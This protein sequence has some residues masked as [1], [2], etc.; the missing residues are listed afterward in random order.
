[1]DNTMALSENFGDVS[2]L[3]AC[4]QCG[5]CSSACPI[6]GVNDFNIRRIVRHIELDLVKEIADTP[7]PWY[8]TTCGRCESVCP[9]GIA[10]LDIIRPLRS[11]GPD[12]LAPDWPPCTK[13]CPAGI[14]IPAYLRLIAEGKPEEACA[15]IL[16]KVPF[17]GILGR[18]CMHPCEDACRR[19]EVFNRP[20]SICALKRYAADNAG[21]VFERASKAEELTGHKVAVIGAGPAGLTAAFYLRKKGHDVTVFEAQSKAGGMM[22]HGIPS[23]RLPEDVLEQEIN[24][25]L[26]VGIQ[27]ETEKRLGKDFLLEDL[28]KDGFEAIFIATGLQLSLKIDMEGSHLDDVLWGIDFLNHVGQGKEITLK[29]RILVVGGGNVAVDVALTALRV[30][31]GA[32]TMACLESRDEMPASPWELEMAVEEGVK[33]MTSWGPK[34][35]LAHDGKVTGAELIQCASVFDEKGDFCPAFND[36]TEKVEV[37]QVIL[38]IGQRADLSFVKENG[39]IAVENGLIVTNE[40]TLETG[41]EGV[42]S[43]GDATQGPGAIIDAIA[44]GR[45][46]ASAI[47]KYLGGDGAIDETLAER[48]ATED[49][50]GKR[51]KGFADLQR[52][53]WP[54]LPIEERHT[55]FSE[56]DL[57]FESDQA[58]GEAK[59][60]LQCDLE[61][62]LGK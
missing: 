22:R 33:L 31:A 39:K 51:E 44:S 56:V 38:A 27:L 16:E 6:T 2:M 53:E 28:K 41:I 45:K 58:M 5:C 29:D 55:G 43:G 54:A 24:R 59:R 18:V 57:C 42:F 21:D 17:P 32:V 34:K 47:D 37:D 60:C 4:E 25:V 46:A 10:I 13:A 15:L 61:L 14:D 23:Y 12:E 30:G 62:T 49:Y 8:C 9:N 52:A 1:M 7:F 19:G 48:P 40:E 26:S 50:T 35:I 36:I 3:T 11:I 20:I